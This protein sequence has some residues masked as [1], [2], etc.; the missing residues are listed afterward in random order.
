MLSCSSFEMEVLL[1]FSLDC[2]EKLSLLLIDLRLCG[3]CEL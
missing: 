3:L 2:P 1:M